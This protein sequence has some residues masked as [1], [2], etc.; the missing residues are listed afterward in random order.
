MPIVGVP[1]GGGALHRD[2]GCQIANLKRILALQAKF[3]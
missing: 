2:T 3:N 1:R